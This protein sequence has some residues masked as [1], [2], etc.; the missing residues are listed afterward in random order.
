MDI[1]S[2]IP[3]NKSISFIIHLNNKCNFRCDY[4]IAWREFSTDSLSYNQIFIFIESIK[5][6][7]KKYEKIFID[8]TWGE[9]TLHKEFIFIVLEILNIEN[10]ILNISTNGLLLYSLSSDL[11]KILF[12][13]N[14]KF[15]I[16]FHYFEYKDKKDI[17]IK[18][19][20]FLKQ[21]DFNFEIKFLLPNNDELLL[22]FLKI[23]DYI[24]DNTKISY[25]DYK[26]YLILN[27]KWDIS[28]TYNK[29]ILDFYY[30]DINKVNDFNKDFKKNKIVEIAYENWT[31][32]NYSIEEIKTLW[33]N[34]FKGYDCFYIS[35]KWLNIHISAKWEVIM[36]P[37][38]ILDKLRY[39]IE[40]LSNILSLENKSILCSENFC[41][42]WIIFPKTK[43]KNY[44][45]IKSLEKLLNSYINRIINGIKIQDIQ[46]TLSKTIIIIFKIDNLNI[47]LII[48]KN[49]LNKNN[50][51][52]IN[53]IW[54]NIKIKDDSNIVHNLENIDKNY[55]NIINKN[56]KVISELDNI[57]L[58]IL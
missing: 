41:I 48:E 23:R 54:Y 3:L 56:I 52:L 45:K 19:I 30:N 21:N 5:K 35:D 1:K 2:A 55:I 40:D 36:W 46:I 11:Q 32:I 26:Y 14:L 28:D 33:L 58:K 37:C 51:F 47:S 7:S 4:C 6:I 12:K 15:N 13:N 44:D 50:Y 53:N 38:N 18:S 20:L 57:F 8:I 31:K 42:S 25:N 39:K 10:I 43:S 34:N 49:I 29:E 9:P 16:S 17:F 24:I 22:D 27:F